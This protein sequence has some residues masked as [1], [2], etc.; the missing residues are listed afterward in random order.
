MALTVVE[1]VVVRVEVEVCRR[2]ERDGARFKLQTKVI[3]SFFFG[4][5]TTSGLCNTAN[6]G[7]DP[8]SNKYRVSIAGTDTFNL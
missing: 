1:I 7:I 4:F 2:K 3:L 8:I 6:V 5:W